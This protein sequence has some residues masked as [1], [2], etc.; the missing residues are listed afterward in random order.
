MFWIPNS[1]KTPDIIS[2]HQEQEDSLARTGM[3]KEKETKKEEERDRQLHS[4]K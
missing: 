4:K 3:K 1:S 2:R